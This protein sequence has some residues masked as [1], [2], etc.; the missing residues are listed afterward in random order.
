MKND[1][2]TRLVFFVGLCGL[3]AS[4]VGTRW[5]LHANVRGEPAVAAE[6][7]EVRVICS[8]HVDV[9]PGVTALYP[10]RP[11]Q[12]E[13][14]YV[15]EGQAVKAGEVLLALDHRPAEYQVRQARAALAETQVQRDQ[16][17]KLVE[18]QRLK[19][20]Q[21]QAVLDALAAKLHAAESLLARRKELHGLAGSD[22]EIDAAQAHCAELRAMLHGE[23]KK[24]E[25]LRLNDPQLSIRRAEADVAGKQAQLDEALLGLDYCEL[26]APGDGMIL[27]VLVHAGEVLGNQ[28]KQPAVWFCPGGPRIVRAEVDQ[29]FAH[30]VAVGQPARID[31]DGGSDHHWRGR[32]Y[33]ISD[34]YT[35]RRS[36][37]QDPLQMN[38]VRT[39]ECL[40]AV[41]PDQAP[42]RIGQR[43]LVTLE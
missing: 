28:P 18:Q 21:Q 41:E 17:A 35:H 42:L 23:Q 16:A 43:V 34:W 36:I 13:R 19:E 25:E 33:R 2:L 10:L 30:R 6:T 4:L 11:G 3:V 14:V 1:R 20:A 38:D 29:E 7:P 27:R 40:I 32:V 22:K 24:L 5:L 15:K 8:G 31:D 37:L 9:E 12:V 26:K 39:L